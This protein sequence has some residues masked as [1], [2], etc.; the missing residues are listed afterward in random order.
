[1]K[2]LEKAK[3][4]I[5]NAGFNIRIMGS[6]DTVLAQLPS[7]GTQLKS[8]ATLVVYTDEESKEKTVTGA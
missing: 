8:G 2:R 1:M 3:T 7:P 4:D 6:G 5:K